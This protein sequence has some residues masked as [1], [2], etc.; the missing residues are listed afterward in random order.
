[1]PS[2][3]PARAFDATSHSVATAAPGNMP[4]KDGEALTYLVSIG[5][6]QAAQGTFVTRDAGDH[7]DCK[8]EL[9]SRGLVDSFYPFTDYFWCELNKTPWRSSEYG[10]FR[11]E[12]GRTIKERTR[13]DY[14]KRQGTREIWSQAKTKTFP[15]GGER[16]R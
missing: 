7:W 8:L 6:F 16:G 3:F 5:M 2:L 13:I 11:F 12:P 15:V 1:M 9:V 10:E 4:W 14:T